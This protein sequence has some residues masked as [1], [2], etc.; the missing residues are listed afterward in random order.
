MDAIVIEDLWV[1][2]RVRGK[3]PPTVKSAVGSL[4]RSISARAWAVQGLSLTVQKGEMYGLIGV[5]GSG[6]STLLRCMAGIFRPTRGTVAV[7][8]RTGSLIDLTAGF[9]MELTAKDNVFLSGAIYGVPRAELT[10]K[11]DDVF[12][13]AGLE[14][15]VDRPMR[16]FSTGMAM[17]LGFSLVV[18][19][20]PDI[21]LVD[22]VLAVGDESFKQRCLEKIQVL[23]R[24]GTTVV[25]A[26]HELALIE[27]LCD[28]VAVLEGG[29]LVDETEAE[30]AVSYYCDRLGIDRD[31]ALTR[32]PLE[33]LRTD[34]PWS[35]Y[36]R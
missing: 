11:L 2:Y 34:R 23:C 33:A 25:F 12:S 5:N 27:S 30:A 8:G 21:I 29:Q 10:A 13:F 16:S 35:R 15:H 32:A 22:E 6:K 1:S 18:A 14:D 7:T 31:E 4:G 20:D 28:R 36:R 9:D 17:R 19:M 24:K 3:K 26:S